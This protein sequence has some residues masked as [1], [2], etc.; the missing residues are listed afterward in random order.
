MKAVAGTQ[1]TLNFF[2]STC[3][4][5]A[6]AFWHGLVV[7]I[8]CVSLSYKMIMQRVTEWTRGMKLSWPCNRWAVAW[9]TYA[10]S[11]SKIVTFSFCV[12][13]SM[14]GGRTGMTISSL[15][16][17]IVLLC[18]FLCRSVP[19]W[20][21][22]ASHLWCSVPPLSSTPFASSHPVFLS[23]PIE[24]DLDKVG[25]WFYWYM[26]QGLCY[27]AGLKTFII[28]FACSFLMYWRCHL[29][30]DIRCCSKL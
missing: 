2:Y 18:I 8:D 5:S 23:L 27:E 12:I 15:L 28:N 9:V 13:F 3:S 14:I 21:N 11:Y 29:Y 7:Q 30:H 1:K 10:G 25:L 16:C 22:T 24:M 20:W 17:L 26:D 6:W 4:A 19:T